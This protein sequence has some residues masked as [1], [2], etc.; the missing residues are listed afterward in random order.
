MAVKMA[1]I[2]KKKNYGISI[3]CHL[4]KVNVVVD[5]LSRK[6]VEAVASFTLLGHLERMEIETYLVGQVRDLMGRL[7]LQPS[8]IDRIRTSLHLD[9][10]LKETAKVMIKEEGQEFQIDA[11][12][13]LSFEG[14]I[15]VPNVLELR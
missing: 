5:A 4:G 14:R 3:H 7:S 12:G 10:K 13:I 9:L 15:C 1:R 6:S 2:K 8:L 11:F